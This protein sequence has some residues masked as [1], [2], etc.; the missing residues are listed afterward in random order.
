MIPPTLREICERATKG[1]ACAL[2]VRTQALRNEDME[3]AIEEL[4]ARCN[5]QTMLVV[6]EAL[7]H[8][9]GFIAFGLEGNPSRRRL[10]GEKIII[11][12]QLLNRTP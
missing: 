3:N 8:A 10:A 12:L 4:T 7:G 1:P 6:I 2:E 9:Q 11:A 5:P